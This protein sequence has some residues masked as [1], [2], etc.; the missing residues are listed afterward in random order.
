MSR[1]QV[2]E[3]EQETDQGDRS[4][5]QIRETCQGDMSGRQVRETDQ[6]DRSGRMIMKQVREKDQETGQGVMSGR[7]SRT[8]VRET[9]Q[10]EGAGNRSGRR[11]RRQIRETGQGEGAGN[12]LLHV[13]PVGVSQPVS[14]GHSGHRARAALQHN[15]GDRVYFNTTSVIECTSTQQR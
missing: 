3:K 8:Q 14:H 5:R 13:R 7:R 9:G 10:G 2:R 15:I 1:R 6:G 12:C 11:I 4:G